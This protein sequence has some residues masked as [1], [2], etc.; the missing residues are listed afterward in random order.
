MLKKHV[1]LCD[2]IKA[3]ERR[4]EDLSKARKDC[5]T[6][7]IDL[8][9][10]RLEMKVIEDYTAQ[11]SREISVAEGD[12]VQLLSNPGGEW[13]K[14]SSADNSQGYIPTSCLAFIDPEET[15]R[16]RVERNK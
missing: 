3:F 14:V 15:T 2:D 6:Q 11:L 16:S 1:T 5:P 8:Q 13:V 10:D 12:T 7:K 9:P 4:M